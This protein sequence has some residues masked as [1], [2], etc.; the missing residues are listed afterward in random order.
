[1]IPESE[2]NV[3]NSNDSNEAKAEAKENYEDYDS[4]GKLMNCLKLFGDYQSTLPL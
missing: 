3:V 2:T 4:Q 1:M